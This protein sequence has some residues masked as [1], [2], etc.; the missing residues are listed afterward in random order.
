[1]LPGGERVVTDHL[2]GVRSVAL[3]LW[4]GTGSRDE[5]RSRAGVSHFIEH[6]L[7]KGRRGT[8]RNA[9]PSS[10]T[11]WAAS[12]TRPPRARRPS[13]THACR[14]P[15]ERRARRDDRHGLRAR[16][17]RRRLRAG[18][19]ARGDRD[20]R[21]QPAGPRPRPRGRGGVRRAS[22]RPT[23]DRQRGRDRAGVAPSAPGLAPP[24]VRRSADRARR[25]RQRLARA[26]GRAVHEPSA[27]PERH[28]ARP[29]PIAG[30]AAA[31][32]RLPVPPAPAEQYH[33]VLAA[34]E[35]HATTRRAT[36]SRFSTRSSAALRRRGS[37]R[38]SANAGGWPTAS[39]RS[40]RNTPRRARWAS[41]SE[42]ARTTSTSASR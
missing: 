12:S 35:S 32:P 21:R 15:P 17:R 33:V 5:P 9:S 37:S 31:A 42:R 3:G 40:A 7:F 27:E 1:M 30:Q 36:P 2:R 13:S 16:R 25:G 11:P 38:R 6:L 10:S 24:G 39:I 34:P 41:T 19:R 26:A 20:G 29:S 14:R 28:A 4:I 23:G 18:G 8:A 22:A